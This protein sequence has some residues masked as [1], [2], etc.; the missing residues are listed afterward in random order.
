MHHCR[1]RGGMIREGGFRL[2]SR[3]LVFAGAVAALAVGAT[4]C[5][6]K[7]EAS[8]GPVISGSTLTIYSSLPL[9]G[10]AGP[11]SQAI[12]NAAKLALRDA[13]GKPGDYPIRYVSLDDST[14]AAGKA[15]DAAVAANA[16]R[17]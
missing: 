2:T 12:A 17:A 5:G 1:A 6:A 10:A 11:Q 3:S 8:V 9:Q 14:A 4:G 16:R 13:G 7:K 15:V